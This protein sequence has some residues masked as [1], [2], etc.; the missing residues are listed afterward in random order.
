MVLAV[1]SALTPVAFRTA[2]NSYKSKGFKTTPVL[3]KQTS[4]SSG[5]DVPVLNMVSDIQADGH[6]NYEYQLGNGI[7]A[8]EKGLGG[9]N[10][11][12]S[13][14]YTSPEGEPIS[15]TYTADENGY[16]PYGSHVP[17][18]PSYILKSLE[19]IRTHAPYD[20]SKHAAAS[21]KS[22]VAAPARA[23]YKAPAVKSVPV[24]KPAKAPAKS[25][26]RSAPV[27]TSTAFKKTPVSAS[28]AYL[29]S[30]QKNG[31]RF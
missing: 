19:Y 30:N 18:I 20:E 15:I 16:H 11:Q 2:P 9:Q 28:R 23:A 4:S 31:R 21:T 5:S 8:S 25:A 27:K 14:Q 24:F 29:K 6:Y 13:F 22:F 12:G 10:V 1:S 26:Y 3:Y 17:E 7:A